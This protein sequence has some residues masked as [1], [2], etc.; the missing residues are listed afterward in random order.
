MYDVWDSEDYDIEVR[1]H[2]TDGWPRPTLE[3]R[4]NGVAPDQVQPPF[5]VIND[6]GDLVLKRK[7]TIFKLKRTMEVYNCNCS[8][9]NKFGQDHQALTVEVYQCK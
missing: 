2:V 5:H 8:A 6:S 7:A 9:K 3:W 1:C 4:V